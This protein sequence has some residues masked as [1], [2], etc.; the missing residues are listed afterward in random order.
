MAQNSRL[1]NSENATDP[2]KRRGRSFRT[3]EDSWFRHPDCTEKES[4]WLEACYRSRGH[5]VERYLNPDLLTW[6]VAVC[7][8]ESKH[9]PRPSRTFQQRIWR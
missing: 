3:S 9:P 1:H 8:P 2:D 5:R 4:C 7:L 6:T